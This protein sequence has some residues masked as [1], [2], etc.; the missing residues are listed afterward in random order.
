MKKLPVAILGGSFNPPTHSHMNICPE[1]FAHLPFI[2]EFW[3]MPCGSRKDKAITDGK[4]RLQM[5][6][7][8]R[9]SMFPKCQQIKVSDREIK[10]GPLIPTAHLLQMLDSNNKDKSFHFIV[11]ADIIPSLDKWDDSEYLYSSANLIIFSRAGYKLDFSGRSYRVPRN[12]S[13][14]DSNNIGPLSSTEVRELMMNLK[15]D[16]IYDQCKMLSLISKN[17]LQYIII[18][19]LYLSK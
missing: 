19:K 14:V 11:G 18:N 5:V 12:Y 10:N 16:D 6:Q 13:Y 15:R 7:L 3:F 17:V 2:K 4:H 8:A 1:V 9:D